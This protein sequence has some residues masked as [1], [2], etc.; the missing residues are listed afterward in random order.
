MPIGQFFHK[1][2]KQK[3]FI[4]VI[5]F[6]GVLGIWMLL[7]SRE[8]VSF[9][10]V[11]NKFKPSDV[12][13]VDARGV[14][15]E[16]LRTTQH[17]RSLDWVSWSEVSPAFKKYLIQTEDQRFYWHIGVDFLALAHTLW[18]HLSSSSS[19]GASTLTMQLVGV[20]QTEKTNAHRNW[21]EKIQQ[22]AQAIELEFSWSKEQILE[23][24]VNLVSF[25]GEIVGLR[26]ASLGY[27]SK[28]PLGLDEE[29]AALLVAL[30]RAPNA[31]VNF[32]SRR[33]CQIL[34]DTDCENLK[35]LANKTFSNSYKL[36]RKRELIPVFSKH[37][38]KNTLQTDSNRKTAVIQTSLDYSLQKKSLEILR[39]HLRSLKSQ[40]VQDGAVLILETQ[41]GRV[42][43]YAANG[44]VGFTSAAQV[45]GIE[46]RRQAGST[47]KPFV[48][49]TAFDWRYLTSDSLLQDAPADLPI[50]QGRV[51]RPKNY[52]LTFRGLVSASEA[53]ASS[54][55]VPA[56]K[57]LEL[58]G[59]SK[60]LDRLHQLGFSN[61]QNDEYYG[62]S[63][64]LGTLDVTL[65]ELTQAYRQFGFS[66]AVFLDSTREAV[67]NILASPEYRRFTFGIESILAL[68][69]AAAVKT[70]TS[71]DM[72]DNWCIGWTPQYTVGV[73]VGNFNGQPMWNV[74]GMS[75][76]APIWRALMLEL[77][78]KSVIDF[79][80]QTSSQI[81]PNSGA[82]SSSTYRPAAKPLTQST[83]S[84]IRYP[85]ADM[86]VGLDPD[87]P[88]ALQKLPI[89]IDYPQNGQK[90]FIN[91][92]YVS[93]AK[94]TT[95]WAIQRGQHKIELKTAQGQVIDTIH[96]QVR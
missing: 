54:L 5:F 43:A 24:Y 79:Q 78:S 50:S 64:A 9:A 40:N 28:A 67:F 63:L 12:W 51:Y 37:I 87:I 89:E 61:L 41:T 26:A 19:R 96:F 76:A 44:G 31:S 48:Y 32:I 85:A 59:E 57:T 91:N 71:K 53:L 80:T 77:H 94:A 11:K 47:L 68:P 90:L 8:V 25:R 93:Q 82:L 46:T 56:V 95:L 45:D 62:P 92:R 1:L 52:D 81:I 3:N 72:R 74:S 69:F 66:S 27:F 35:K 38:L 17:Q 16:S 49:A 7:A 34:P 88:S 55:N 21:I 20:L 70:G 73:W 14:P 13:L 39:D 10:E 36:S 86:F 30:I 60:V 15:L 33:A 75:G 4:P 22:I 6:V 58:V 65:W 83:L 84:R 2:K 23:A 42:V 18:Q 29:E